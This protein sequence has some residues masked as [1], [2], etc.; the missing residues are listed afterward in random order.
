MINLT[1]NFIVKCM[2]VEL[3]GYIVMLLNVKANRNYKNGM[4]E[5]FS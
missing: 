5:K 2:R 3:Q 1:I 4:H